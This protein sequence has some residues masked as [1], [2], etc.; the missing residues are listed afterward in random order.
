MNRAIFVGLLA[1]GV[2]AS[3]ASGVWAGRATV[4][5]FFRR[6][7]ANIEYFRDRLAPDSSQN[8][9]G[10]MF[11][12]G[13]VPYGSGPAASSNPFIV[14]YLNGLPV[15]VALTGNSTAADP[16]LYVHPGRPG[17]RSFH[18]AMPLRSS[19]DHPDSTLLR[20]VL[21]PEEADGPPGYRVQL[22]YARM[23][24]ISVQSDSFR[25]FLYD[26][27]Q[28]G[29]YSRDHGDG[30]FVDLNRDRSVEIDGM[31]PEFGPF[32]VPFQL[33][34]TMFNVSAVH[35]E[36]DWIDVTELGMGKGQERLRVG[37]TAPQIE[38]LSYDGRS[39]RLADYAGR[40]TLLYFWA[41]WCSTCRFQAPGLH[42]LYR[43]FHPRGLEILGF[44]YDDSA[45]AM[46]A[47]L[48]KYKHDWL[49]YSSSGRKNWEDPI[50]RAYEA[51]GVGLLYLVDSDGKY[52]GSFTR[53]EDVRS[54][55]VSLLAP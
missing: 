12:R 20:I 38:C 21:E 43:D 18:L 34:G 46:R 39:M 55:L 22:I 47:H 17:T 49:T 13:Y 5:T 32:S 54:R 10:G 29:V 14:R 27:N 33:G 3:N 31:S 52:L 42:D 26:G 50:A 2:I 16:H 45:S 4:R 37:A 1:G 11:W 30:I 6:E 9:A 36:G 48:A 35:P 15:A 19:V 40:V 28:D 51:R 44:S 25:A 8:S 24:W 23:G 53:I 41:S 7:V